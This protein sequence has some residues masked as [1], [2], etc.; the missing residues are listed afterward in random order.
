MELNLDRKVV[1]V[2]GGKKGIGKGIALS[3]AKEGAIP[4]VIDRNPIDEDFESALRTVCEDFSYFT[5]DLRDTD[6]IQSVVDEVIGKY[7]SLYGVVNNAGANDNLG[8]E[9]T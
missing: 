5:I 8:L 9:D 2:T 7:G 6:K 3:L 1:A 4:V